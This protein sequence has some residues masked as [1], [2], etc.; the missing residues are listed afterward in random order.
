MNDLAK[1]TKGIG[2]KIKTNHTGT[3]VVL[4]STVD[5]EDR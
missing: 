4:S 2:K 1:I 3:K 5:R